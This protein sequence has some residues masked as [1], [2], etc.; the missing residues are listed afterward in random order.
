MQYRPAAGELL[1]TIGDVLD[2]ELRPALPIE[3]QHKARVAANVA[4]ILERE[5]GLAPQAAQRE[6]ERLAGIL[7]HDGDVVALAAELAARLR[8]GD[9]PAFEVAAWELL[10]DVSRGD[11]AIAKPGHDAWEG[12]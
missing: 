3:L 9:D 10:V 4:R 6:R 5:L 7:G 12:E 2:D 1:S 8:A 11:L